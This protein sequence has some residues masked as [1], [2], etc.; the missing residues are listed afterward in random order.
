MLA[1]PPNQHIA[2]LVLLL[3]HVKLKKNVSGFSYR[4]LLVSGKYVN[5]ALYCTFP[6]E[7]ASIKEKVTINLNACNSNIIL[8]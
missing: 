1:P 6:L 7:V 8:M 3:L 2:I 5:V 4:S